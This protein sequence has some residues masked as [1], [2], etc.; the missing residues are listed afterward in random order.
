MVSGIK[1]MVFGGEGMFYVKLTGPGRVIMQTLPF[2]R[3]AERVIAHAPAMKR[4][5]SAGGVLGGIL[6]D[7]G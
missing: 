2:S 3:L 4:Q 6:G 5:G 1:N 7:R